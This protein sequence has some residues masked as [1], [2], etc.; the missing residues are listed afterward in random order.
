MLNR[1]ITPLE[2]RIDYLTLQTGQKLPVPFV[3]LVVFATNIRPAE[4]RRRSVPPPDPLQG[5]RREPDGGRLQA[6]LPAAAARNAALD[7]DEALVDGL[8]QRRVH[9]ARHSAAR[10]ATRAT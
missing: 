8:V 6:D 5:V 7:Y 9:A 3:V 1:W 10:H 4:L 2:S